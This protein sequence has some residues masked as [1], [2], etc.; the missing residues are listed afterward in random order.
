MKKGRENKLVLAIMYLG[1]VIVLLGGV[2]LIKSVLL[3]EM[4]LFVP[5]VIILIVGAILL[6]VGIF[7]DSKM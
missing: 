6:L 3:F 7:S 5:S 1:L 4:Y 2:G